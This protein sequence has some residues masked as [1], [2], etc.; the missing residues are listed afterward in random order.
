M[1]EVDI[2]LIVIA[3]VL[4]VILIFFNL[5]VMAHY[6]DPSAAAGHFF[7]KLVIVFSSTVVITSGAVQYMHR[8][9]QQVAT[10]ASN[11]GQVR[12]DNFTACIAT[13][14]GGG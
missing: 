6:I 11:R 14:R 10:A 4:P 8:R 7:A 5:V 3:C 1:V 9:L 13:P 2:G 12:Q